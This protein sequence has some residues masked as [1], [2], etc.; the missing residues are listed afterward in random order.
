[1]DQAAYLKHVKRVIGRFDHPYLRAAVTE[2]GIDTDMF[3]GR[4]EMFLDR[5][6]ERRIISGREKM[7]LYEHCGI[8]GEP[9]A[10]GEV[11][12]A[13]EVSAGRV[14][15]DRVRQIAAR[16]YE[17]LGG[18]RRSLEILG[19]L[20]SGSYNWPRPVGEWHPLDLVPSLAEDP[21]LFRFLRCVGAE[22]VSELI[23]FGERGF[24][25]VRYYGPVVL[26]KLKKKLAEHGLHLKGG[27]TAS[28]N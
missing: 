22:T 14:A 13:S 19:G 25:Y 27:E 28:K 18:D 26:G 11:G 5:A 24:N 4:F 10:L 21:S 23:G 12:L 6:E 17:R 3:K 15:A 1:M 2:D 16:G 9:K 7:V 20:Y 8:G